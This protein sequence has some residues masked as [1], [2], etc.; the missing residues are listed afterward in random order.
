MDLQARKISL[1]SF[2]SHIQDEGFIEKVERFIKNERGS[3]YEK[4]MKPMTVDELEQKIEQSKTDI[5]EG[6][7]FTQKE[8]S[9]FI[10]KK[11][12]Q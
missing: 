10:N 2:L 5:A 6:R 8:V 9:E 4:N 11:Y 1:I 7:F 12:E 3:S